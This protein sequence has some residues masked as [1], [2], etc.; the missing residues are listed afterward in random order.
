VLIELEFLG[1][2]ERVPV[3]VHSVIRYR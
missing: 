2:S 1:G 3:P